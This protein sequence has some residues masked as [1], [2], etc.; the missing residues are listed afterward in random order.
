MYKKNAKMTHGTCLR[1][2]E[3]VKGHR[4]DKKYCSD[5]CRVQDSLSRKEKGYR[6]RIIWGKEVELYNFLQK[7]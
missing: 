4:F 2:G 5:L 1:C 6:K 7:K 3:S